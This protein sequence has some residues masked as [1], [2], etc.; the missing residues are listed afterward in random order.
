[1]T[2][3]NTQRHNCV[4]RNKAFD[5]DRALCL[6]CLVVIPPGFLFRISL[7]E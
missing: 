5:F 6:S 4:R 1:M 2:F 3:P 7:S